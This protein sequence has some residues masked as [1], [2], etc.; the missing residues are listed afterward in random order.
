MDPKESETLVRNN[1]SRHPG[2]LQDVERTLAERRD[3]RGLG[4]ALFGNFLAVV[5]ERCQSPRG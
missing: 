3:G 2:L 5:E 1:L 4:L